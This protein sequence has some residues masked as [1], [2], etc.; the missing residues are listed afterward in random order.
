MTTCKIQ[1][2]LKYKIVQAT[3]FVFLIQ[4]AQ[5]ADQTI[6]EEQLTFNSPVTWREFQD[7]SHKNRYIRL[8]VEACDSFEVNYCATVER[9]PVKN[10]DLQQKLNEVAIPDLPDEVLPYLLASRYCNSD[11]FVEMANRSFGWMEQGYSRIKAIE[12][13]IYN[14]IFYVSGSSDQ[15]TTA[16][17]VLIHRAGVCRD[18]AHLGIALCRALGIPA[19]MV[20]GY[21]EIENFLPDFHAIFEAYLD[22]GWVLFDP[23]RLATV[24]N[25]IRI[26]TGIDAGD[27]AF[28]TF[29]GEIELIK[30]EPIITQKLDD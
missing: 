22:G 11:L 27:V 5:H 28:S 25:L 24:E 4:V 21:V 7:S 14:N 9:H 17:D 26:G 10:A 13:W 6:I 15:F 3:E 12:Q 18:F 8:H 29:Y 19:R 2:H 1:C 16:T 23:T 20:V 30:I